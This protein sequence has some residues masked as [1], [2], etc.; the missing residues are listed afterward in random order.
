MTAPQRRTEAA[1]LLALG[2]CRLRGGVARNGPVG[3]ASPVG[4][5][6]GATQRVYADSTNR[7]PQA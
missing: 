1:A 4:L 5:G 7:S 2:L 3:S 6:F